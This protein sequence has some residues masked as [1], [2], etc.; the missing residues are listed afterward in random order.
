V[1]RFSCEELV[2]LVTVYL[3]GEIGEPARHRFE[4]HLSVCEGCA[5]YLGQFRV[6]VDAL[7]NLPSEDETLSGA[8]RDRLLAAFRDSRR[9]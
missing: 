3:D 2:E 8:V 5:R 6:T 4:D 1:K 9:P 7:G